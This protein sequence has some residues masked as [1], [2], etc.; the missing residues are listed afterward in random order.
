MVRSSW[1][2]FNKSWSTY[3]SIIESRELKLPTI[4]RFICVIDVYA[5]L[6]CESCY[7]VEYMW[8][9]ISGDKRVKSKDSWVSRSCFSNFFFY[10]ETHTSLKPSWSLAT[11]CL[12]AHSIYYGNHILGFLFPAEHVHQIS[13]YY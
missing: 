1:L 13:V 4:T 5:L 3:L 2:I 9:S 7:T 8:N 6:L 12:P 11:P 10:E